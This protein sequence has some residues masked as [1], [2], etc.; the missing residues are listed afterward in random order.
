[1]VADII[2]PVDLEFK[3]IHQRLQPPRFAPFFDNCIGAI[4]GT[5]I[6]VV[7]P[8]SK[9]VQHTG[10]HEYTTQNVLAICDFDMRFTF[11]VAGWPRSVHD[12]RVFKDAIEKYGDKFPHPPEGKFYLVDLSYPNRKGYLAPCKGTKY[13]LQEFRNGPMPGGKKE[14]FNYAHSSLRNVIEGSFGVLKMKWR[15]LLNLPSY[16]MPKQSKIIMGCMSL[17]NF[18]RESYLGD[19]D[20]DLCDH[21][22]NYVPEIGVICCRCN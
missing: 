16:P 13:H 21:D 17:Y 10:R 22:E 20:F 18:I 14:N 7:V 5:L 12:M 11:V 3:T 1:L 15:I 19:K 2:R 4:D 6:P 9:V 8:I